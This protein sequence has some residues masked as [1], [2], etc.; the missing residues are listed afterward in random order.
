MKNASRFATAAE[1]K[2]DAALIE[3]LFSPWGEQ[4]RTFFTLAW[5][6]VN[7]TLDSADH[8]ALTL[9]VNHM[10][11]RNPKWIAEYTHDF[12]RDDHRWLTGIVTA[13]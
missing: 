10:I 7:S 1:E 3:A 4:G 2:S 9:N 6:R 13:F 11:R 12:E 5:N 8:Q